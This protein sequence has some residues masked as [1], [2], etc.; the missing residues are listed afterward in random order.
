VHFAQILSCILVKL[1][2]RHLPFARI[3]KLKKK[4]GAREKL[5]ET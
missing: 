3:S 5:S 1:P 2:T 4:N